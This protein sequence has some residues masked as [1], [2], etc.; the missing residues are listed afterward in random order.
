[1][2]ILGI[3]TS[4]DET[5]AAVL[6]G[7]VPRSNVVLSQ[8]EHGVYGGVVPELASR[9]HI[10][11][12]IPV[13]EQ[14]LREAEIHLREL[15]AIA[16]T[17]RPGLVGSL[18]VGVNAAKGIAL[19]SDKPLIGVNHL[20]GHIFSNLIEHEIE[21]PFLC[22]L[23]SGGHTEL[24]LVRQLGEYETLGRTL[25]DAAGE[26]FDKVA[27]LL[28]LLPAEGA[29]MGGRLISDR[30]ADGD[31]LAFTFPRALQRQEDRLDFSFSG[32][33][34]AVLNQVNS[35]KAAGSSAL[36]DRVAD[37]AASFQVAVV[38]ALVT[39]TVRAVELTGVR[40]VTLAG[41]VAANRLLRSCLQEAVENLG[42]ACYIP[43]PVLCTDNAA[44]IAAAGQHHLELGEQD[45][46]D[47][48][49]L[50]RAPL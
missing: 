12:V 15:E 6:D 20:E 43:S 41:G 21:V 35:L 8:H 34:T 17:N 18:I 3:E 38:D 32:L 45:G 2:L 11:T 39:K 46:Y 23:V 7:M 19:A 33:K 28:G 29:V 5:S 24:L 40:S 9:A 13:I 26:A 42:A 4:C 10:R 48:D 14:A 37:I 50:P 49:A 16:V 47:L 44:M 36:A 22:L 27:K 25:D 1:M 31:A 30:A